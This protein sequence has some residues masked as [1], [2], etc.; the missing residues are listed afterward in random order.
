MRRGGGQGISKYP[1]LPVKSSSLSALNLLRKDCSLNDNRSN[2][3]RS[4]VMKSA[5]PSIFNILL[6][7]LFKG[8]R[9]EGER[10]E[11]GRK[12]GKD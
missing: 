7:P 2:T 11:K 5:A 6:V 9:K 8:R 3:A 4:E 10:K 1:F 12:E